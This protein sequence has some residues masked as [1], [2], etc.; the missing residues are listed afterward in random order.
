MT[1]ILGIDLSLTRTGIAILDGDGIA[2]TH[3]TSK[4]RTGATPTES[5]ARLDRLCTE[6]GRLL[7]GL[8][9]IA[10][11][12]IEAPAMAHANAGTSLLNGL[13]WSFVRELWA[14]GLPVAAIPPTSLKT[15]ATGKGNAGKDEVLLSVAR[16]FPSVS[17]E[18]NDQADA[19]VL[20]A[21]GWHHAIG[22]SW[23]ELPATHTR[24]LA[25]VQWPADVPAAVAYAGIATQQRGDSA[26]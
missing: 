11:V 8:G 21:M 13:W 3:I 24:A 7:D 17:I 26:S 12:A 15:Y 9:T 1:T 20:A 5:A 23:V 22:Q 25:K 16:R 10:L 2:V 14:R 4:G 19:V 6:L 18:T